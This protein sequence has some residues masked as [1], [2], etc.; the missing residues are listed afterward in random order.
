MATIL[1]VEDDRPLRKVIEIGLRRAGHNVLSAPNGLE[2]TALL[3]PTGSLDLVIT[4]VFMPEMDGFEVM[5]A[6]RVHDPGVK[7]L[8]ISGGERP[9][10]PDFLALAKQLGADD[11]LPKPFTVDRLIETVDAILTRPTR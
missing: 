9:P 3:G 11:S 4:D 8:V 2:A 1:V 7:I 5:K 10:Y 6:I